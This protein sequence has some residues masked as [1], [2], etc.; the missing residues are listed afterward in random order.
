MKKGTDTAKAPVIVSAHWDTPKGYPGADDN[1][2]GCSALLA[3][4]RVLSDV[5][6]ERTVVFVMFGLEE[7]GYSGRMHL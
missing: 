3:I 6:I 2:S 4:A 5:T 1:A 7:V